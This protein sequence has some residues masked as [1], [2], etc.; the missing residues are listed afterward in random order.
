MHVRCGAEVTAPLSARIQ[1]LSL[2]CRAEGGIE[3]ALS[4]ELAPLAAGVIE[5]W[6]A[7]RAWEVVLDEGQ[8]KWMRLWLATEGSR[9]NGSGRG[10]GKSLFELALLDEGARRWPQSKGRWCGLTGE[11]AKAIVSQAY[12][13]YFVTCPREL[14]PQ[15]A[16][17]D[18]QYA[19]NGSLVYVIGTDAKSFRRARGQHRLSI[20]VRDEYGFYQRPLEV[21]AALDAGLLLVGPSGK[22]GRPYY[23]TTPSDS[24]AHESNQVAVAHRAR[25]AYDHETLFDNPRADPEVTIRDI[26]QKTAQTREQVLASTQFRREYLGERVVEEKRA[27][28]PRWTN[29]RGAD[30]TKH[31]LVVV[32]ERP[33]YFDIYEALDPGKKT[34][35][36]A[37]LLAWFDFERQLLYFEHELEL[38]SV[39]HT[40]ADIAREIKKLEEQAFGL[41]QWNGT[42][43]GAKHW[44]EKYSELPEYLQEVVSD[45]APRQPFLRIGDNDD[46][47]LNSLN[48]DHGIAIF[49]TSKHDKHLAVDDFNELVTRGRIKVH[50]RCVRLIAQLEGTIWNEKRTEWV[51]TSADHGDLFDDALYIT[52]NV[53]W[54]RDPRPPPPTWDNERKP[55]SY[56]KATGFRSRLG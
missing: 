23:G 52:R 16:G 5:L 24:P 2:V 50:P 47:L 15:W 54:H 27:A 3:G 42:L 29:M 9:F 44:Q 31:D 32:L 48:N 40:V 41:N 10:R 19:H 11:T 34:D 30:P 33:E 35:P 36:H 37:F 22:P 45:R 46:L 8:Q 6:Y 26:M 55:N 20:D 49:P 28:V 43:F 4:T 12:D 14:K 17:P 13:D 1:Q 25:G 39:R 51:R 38:A 56:E 21:D 53:H 18:L 7:N